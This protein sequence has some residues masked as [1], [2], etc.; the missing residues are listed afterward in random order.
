MATAAYHTQPAR[1]TTEAVLAYL[2]AGHTNADAAAHFGIHERSIRRIKQRAGERNNS[3]IGEFAQGRNSD[4]P[5][6]NV[7]P[8]RHPVALQDLGAAVFPPTADDVAGDHTMWRCPATGELMPIVPGTR[9]KDWERER[10]QTH[11]RHVAAVMSSR[12]DR[13][14]PPAPATGQPDRTGPRLFT[15]WESERT[16]PDTRPD[17][18][19]VAGHVRTAEHP[20]PVPLPP[21]PPEPE[22]DPLPGP[23]PDALPKPPLVQRVVV[24]V[25]VED[26]S[27]RSGGLLG[28][29]QAHDLLGPGPWL[30]LLVFLLLVALTHLG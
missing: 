19:L 23:D 21:G 10:E 30:A 16:G 18:T 9:R 6:T 24:R 1:P 26:R 28:W 17:A 4:R 29:A 14:Q 25:P 12:A 13:T 22:P 5:I 15:A 3:P 20:R 2:A 27:G 7:D 8:D 11:A